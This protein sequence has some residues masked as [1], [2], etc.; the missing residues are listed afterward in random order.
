[1]A[2]GN[3]LDT[4]IVEIKADIADFT[5]G[6]EQ[7][8]REVE[9]FGQRVRHDLDIDNMLAGI[10][11]G[12]ALNAALMVPLIAAST[13]AARTGEVLRREMRAVSIEAARA[14]ALANGGPPL[15]EGEVG[16]RRP[17][18]DSE[19]LFDAANGDMRAGSVDDP[20][21][22]RARRTERNLK[23]GTLGAMRELGAQMRNLVADLAR[24]LGRALRPGLRVFADLSLA[25]LGITGA[26]PILQG[27][28]MGLGQAIAAA[29]AAIAA[30]VGGPIGLLVIGIAALVALFAA[31]NWDKF[32]QF[33]AW[34]GERVEQV[35]GQRFQH[36]V[37]AAQRA[38]SEFVGIFTALWERVAPFFREHSDTIFAV[39]RALSELILGVLDAVGAGFEAF[40]T[41]LEHVFGTI[42]A[43]IRGDWSEAWRHFGAIFTTIWS[44]LIDIVG[45]VIMGIVRAV[46]QFFPGFEQKWTDFWTRV[47]E[48]CQRVFGA[49]VNWL[50]EKTRQ[51]GDFFAGLFDRVVGHSYIP[52]MV[53]GIAEHVARLQGE[54][55]DPIREATEESASAFEEMS[56]R[57]GEALDTLQGAVSGAIEGLIRGKG[58]SF[59]DF[60]RD[61]VGSLGN[62]AIGRSME[63]INGILGP[64]FDRVRGGLGLPGGGYG[65]PPYAPGNSGRA[66]ASII[67]FNFPPGTD[68]RS[69]QQS[70]GQISAMLMRTVAQGRRFA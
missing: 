70:Q 57:A 56:A 1:M 28:F 61:I 33:F 27:L 34:L 41:L 52:D 7:A 6:L 18:R 63:G 26:L 64:L 60:V 13:Q 20:G 31:A 44:G 11:A 24:G 43:L 50:G 65:T 16:A 54:M 47:A 45:S 53:D 37:A 14:R 15:I 10:D 35:L 40:F 17:R 42:G 22:D 4:L 12:D 21:D 29:G 55:V 46:D 51:I 69:F 62:A 66:G 36:I 8:A 39:L 5:R 3:L 19:D 49:V 59:G 38:W 30:F 48:V 68:A 9:R 58:F 67:N 25:L 2:V 23:R 32:Q